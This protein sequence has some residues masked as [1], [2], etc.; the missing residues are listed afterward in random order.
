MKGC[1]KFIAALREEG[2]SIV[3]R[4]LLDVIDD[5]SRIGAFLHFQLE[6]ELFLNGVE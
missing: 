2:E 4:F 3:R 1:V 6:S 5:E